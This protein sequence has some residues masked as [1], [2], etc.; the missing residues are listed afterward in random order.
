MSVATDKQADATHAV[1]IINY[2][3][4]KTPQNKVILQ[5]KVLLNGRSGENDDDWFRDHLALDSID[6]L[7]DPTTKAHD[8]WLEHANSRAFYFG[9]GR[10]KK[11]SEYARGKNC[12]A[13]PAIWFDVDACKKLSDYSGREFYR[14][15]L[16]AGDFSA[17]IRSSKDGVQGWFRLD[18]PLTIDDEQDV[19]RVEKDLKALLQSICYYF[20]GDPAVCR[21]GGVMRL[22][23]SLNKDFRVKAVYTDKNHP[24]WFTMQELTKRFKVNQH[25]VPRVYFYAIAKALT[26]CLQHETGERIEGVRHNVMVSFLG[27]L[28]QCGLDAETAHQLLIEIENYFNLRESEAASIRTTWEKDPES[29]SKMATLKSGMNDDGPWPDSDRLIREAL[30]GDPDK[31]GKAGWLKLKDWYCKQHNI[32]WQQETTVLANGSLQKDKML[33]GT[34]WEQNGETWFME[35]TKSGM[36]AARFANFWIDLNGKILKMPS[37][38]MVWSATVTMEGETPKM[39]EIPVEKHSDFRTLQKSVEGL[40][41]GMA[42]FKDAM[43]SEFIDGLRKSC[44]SNTKLETTH[45]GILGLD[46]GD[47]HFVIPDQENPHYIFL[48][49]SGS[50]DPMAEGALIKTL[51]PRTIQRYLEG[52]GEHY[53]LYH[54][55]YYAYPALGWFASTFVAPFVRQKLRYF[56]VLFVHGLW[57]SGKTQIIEK[58]LMNHFGIN[59]LGSCASTPWSIKRA[60]VSAN[61]GA[62]V[63]DEYGRQ[64]EKH[65][66]GIDEIILD[67]CDGKEQA[68]GSSGGVR[69]KMKL[70]TP[71]CIMGESE[72]TDIACVSRSYTIKV[73][74][75]FKDS[76]QAELND[77]ESP[78]SLA[79]EW[80]HDPKHRCVM[81]SII[82]QWVSQNVERTKEIVNE[83][84]E[85]VPVKDGLDDRR[86]H[87][88]RTI[89]SGLLIL[90][91]IYKELSLPFFL[92]REE[93]FDSIRQ[94][95]GEQ[96]NAPAADFNALKIILS[97][98]DSMVVSP[99]P[100]IRKGVD[101]FFEGKDES[102]LVINV[103]R[104][105]RALTENTSRVRTAAAGQLNSFMDILKA[106]I[107]SPHQFVLS[108][109]ANSKNVPIETSAR[110]D[111]NAIRSLYQ[112]HIDQWYLQGEP[113]DE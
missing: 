9:C 99:L 11:A 32:K 94:K 113:I 110:L 21:L 75:A 108:I 31:P 105:H 16:E 29:D 83:A 7:I 36:E 22:P 95:G 14:E 73:N 92:S 27:T 87:S 112:I 17:L 97:D 93:M 60:L 28:K 111:V 34:F 106:N 74:R 44:P 82:F 72:Y 81:S 20:G 107:H 53:P 5:M 86:A 109:P 30:L 67:V 1:D 64:T 24:T 6:E 49:V 13:V 43:W 4:E 8:V 40:P 48:P 80:L 46:H 41:A 23:G 100:K 63:F 98:T 10:F 33:G 85:L 3:H 91:A 65:K 42:I 61:I 102:E 103:N 39:V 38:K 79:H 58:V 104:W 59:S 12:T 47:P 57:G 35:Q 54:E 96:E 15:I 25:T 50:D 55:P 18:E 45:Y 89:L 70:I 88:Y 78:R 2:L 19:K 84:K 77:P 56:P 26:P 66:A 52:F 90:E 71:L 51:A 68:S 76:V 62:C 37:R 69:I 101:F